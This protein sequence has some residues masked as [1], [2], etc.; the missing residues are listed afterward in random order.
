MAERN[1]IRYEIDLRS[2]N[3]V[4]PGTDIAMRTLGPGDRDELAHLI[5]DAYRG[6][7]DYEG[8]T[9]A[10]A[11]AAI[12]EWLDDAPMFEASFGAQDG[13]SLVS[14]TLLQV[15]DSN[16]FISIVMTHPAHKSKGYGSAAVEATLDMLRS[17]GYE[18]VVFFITEGNTASEKLFR[19][20]GAVAVPRR[21]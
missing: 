17:R 12:D 21:Q 11:K 19:N 3:S 13:E 6:T 2:W 8:E 1:K 5:L 14:A 18:K 20:L 16:P 10:E 7:I 9:L 4:A 15:L